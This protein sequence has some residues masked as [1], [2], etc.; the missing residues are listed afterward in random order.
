M[1]MPK[2][3]NVTWTTASSSTTTTAAPYTSG[4]NTVYKIDP[5]S[6]SAAPPKKVYTDVFDFMPDLCSK[7]YEELQLAWFAQHLLDELEFF[8]TA[9][10]NIVTLYISHRRNDFYWHYSFNLLAVNQRGIYVISQEAARRFL[11]EEEIY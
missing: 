6:Y 5:V 1:E 11:M 7:V 9:D 10:A 8:V 2:S 4:T 3:V